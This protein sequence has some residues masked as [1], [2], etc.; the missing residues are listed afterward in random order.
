MRLGVV[1]D[2]DGGEERDKQERRRLCLWSGRR[3]GRCRA[4]IYVTCAVG[5]SDWSWQLGKQAKAQLTAQ[6]RHEH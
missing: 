5:N 3:A 6:H 2:E 1:V 4:A